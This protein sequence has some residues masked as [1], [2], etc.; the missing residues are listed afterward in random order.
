VSPQHRRYGYGRSKGW[1]GWLSF[2]PISGEQKRPT[3]RCSSY[4]DKGNVATA[5]NSLGTIAAQQ[6]DNERARALLQENMEVLRKLEE[7]GSP[8]IMLKRFH[9]L[10]LLG[11]LAIYEEEDYARGTAL[12][13][14]SLA[15]ARDIGDLDRIGISLSNLGHPALLQGDYERARALSEEVLALARELGSSGVDLAPSASINLGLAL[16]GLGEH[17]RAA[18][19]FEKALVMSQNMGRKP[20]VI[21]SLEGMAGL[22]GALGKDTRA[23][24]LWGAAEATREDTGIA[25]SPSER[26]LHEPYLNSARSRL[27]ETAWEEALA[28]GRAMSL[29]RATEYALSREE[30]APPTTLVPHE[31]SIG[32]PKDVLTVREQEVALLAAR[33]L[34]NRQVSTQLGISE[35]TAGNHVARILRKLEL[36]SRAQIAGWANESRLLTPDSD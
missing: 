31:P 27:E 25:L 21:E 30:F 17:E 12:W 2:K 36:R 35:R 16:L 34:T 20:Q 14:E 10:N 6:G 4:L 15:L 7:E 28:E 3:K 22:A 1:D 29:D 23:A 26:A 13:E 11:Y 18:T 32:K 33:G 9:A 19:P 24:R 5:L 8:A